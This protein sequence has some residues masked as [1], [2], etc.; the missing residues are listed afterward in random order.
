MQC[1]RAEGCCFKKETGNITGVEHFFVYNEVPVDRR[2]MWGR[3]M[4]TL[5]YIHKIHSLSQPFESTVDFFW[6]KGI[7]VARLL[8]F[9]ASQTNEVPWFSSKR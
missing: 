2:K 3:L 4:H 1:L 5:L 7:L 9:T 8:S 6:G